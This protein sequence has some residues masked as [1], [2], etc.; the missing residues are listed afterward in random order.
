MLEVTSRS[1]SNQCQCHLKALIIVRSKT[2]H[3]DLVLYVKGQT[4]K[5]SKRQI[6]TQFRL[7]SPWGHCKCQGQ[8]QS[9][10]QYQF[11]TFYWHWAIDRHLAVKHMSLETTANVVFT[12]AFHCEESCDFRFSTKVLI[13]DIVQWIRKKVWH[14][15]LWTWKEMN[16]LSNKIDLVRLSLKVYTLWTFIYG[17]RF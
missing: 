5:T 1:I 11:Q 12:Q 6:E 10:D 8:G 4:I 13:N 17:V 15:K 2:V 7:Y 9:W 16:S 14:P 3:F